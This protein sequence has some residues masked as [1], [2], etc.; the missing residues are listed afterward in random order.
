VRIRELCE[1]AESALA[2]ED[3]GEAFADFVW[4]AA[5]LQARDRGLYACLDRCL[6]SPEHA[7][8][9]QLVAQVTERAQAAGAVR[10][11]VPAADV[12]ALVGAA[13]RASRGDEWRRY[14]EVV[15]DGL[16]PR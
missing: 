15:L 16:R 1:L 14:L 13:L 3:P 8:L 9:E 2:A 11:D 4:A 5:E 7:E 12:P 6:Q 10:E